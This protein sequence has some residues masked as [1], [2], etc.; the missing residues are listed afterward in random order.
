MTWF[1][2]DDA[3]WRHRKVRALGRRRSR[4]RTQ[5]LGL[6]L[7]V[8]TWSAEN[9]TDGFVPFEVVDEW[10]Y[11]REGTRRLVEVGLWDESQLAGEKGIQF[12]EWN[13]WQPTADQVRQRQKADAD[14]RARW[15]ASRRDTARDETRDS[16]RESPRDE[17]R[18]SRNGHTVSHG[19]SHGV[20][21]AAPVP[22]PVPSTSFGPALM[23]GVQLGDASA[24]DQQPPPKNDHPKIQKRPRCVRHTHLADDDPGPNCLDCR[25]ARVS[26][27]I[28]PNDNAALA[29]KLRRQA[30]NNCPACD[31]YGWELDDIGAPAVPAVKCGH[32]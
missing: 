1:K 12:H 7:A 22:V 26:S 23:G 2:V 25:D 11:K 10:D 5:S 3:F 13:E 24:H 21:H 15:R 6:W 16:Q 32:L 27:G 8:G 30:I 19:V 14:R 4:R 9:R 31:E 29:K 28:G 18:E 20:S 17:T